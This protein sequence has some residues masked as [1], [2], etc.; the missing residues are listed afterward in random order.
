MAT[1]GY[2]LVVIMNWDTWN[3]LSPEI[4]QVFE[5]NFDDWSEENDNWVSL[6]DEAGYEFAESLGNT[7]LDLPAEEIQGF[8][9]LLDANFR[10]SMAALDAKGY[11]ATAI[12][13]EIRS[14]VEGQ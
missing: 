9:D 14:V 1:G 4:Q 13:E 7:F 3:S 12:Y 5:D 8:Y 11:N 6:S 10:A 2:G